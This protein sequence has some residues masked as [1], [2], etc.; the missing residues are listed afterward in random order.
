MAEVKRDP[1][2]YI[3]AICANE[4]L[5]VGDDYEVFLVNRFFS[6]FVDTVLYANE[7]NG[8]SD[9]MDKQLHFDFYYSV[10]K[11]KKRW[12][13]WYKPKSERDFMPICQYYDISMNEARL[14]SRL[15]DD[16]MY[17]EIVRTLDGN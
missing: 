2:K 16:E 8:Y 6:Y 11:R 5:E 13:K 3:N 15:I 4:H 17:A 10:V 12:A 9:G 14:R 7:M 1:F